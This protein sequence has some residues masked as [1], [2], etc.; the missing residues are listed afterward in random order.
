[1]LGVC[2]ICRRGVMPV[3]SLSCR[4]VFSPPF[5]GVSTL[6]RAIMFW[7]SCSHTQ[8]QH[9]QYIRHYFYTFPLTLWTVSVQQVITSWTTMTSYPWQMQNINQRI[10]EC[11][12]YLGATMNNCWAMTLAHLSKSNSRTFQ[13][14]S[15]TIQR[16]CKENWM[17]SNRH[18]NKHI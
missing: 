13:E 17:K 1:V 15:R 6:D 16:I 2:E 4:G 7:A 12:F 11:M 18:F 14:L 5:N 9:A 8:T 10:R 3:K